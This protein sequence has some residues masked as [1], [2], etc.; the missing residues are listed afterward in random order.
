MRTIK[1]LFIFVISMFLVTSCFEETTDLDLNDD[2]FNV[3]GFSNASENFAA[4]ADGAEYP[5]QIEL[6]LIGPTSMELTEDVTVSFL[7]G[8]GS[9]AIEGTHYRIDDASVTL[10]KSNNYLG[11][12]NITMLTEGIETPLDE[13]PVL[14]LLT[15]AS[16]PA[17]VSGTGKP[18][19]VVF[20]YACF[21]D[22]AGRYDIE[23]LRDGGAIAPYNHDGAGMVDDI[24]ET[25]VGEYRTSNVGHWDW[26]T[27]LGGAGVAGFTFYDVCGVLTVP[28]QNL[29]EYYSNV[30]HGDE[31]PDGEVKPDGTLI[32]TYKI[33]SSWESEYQ[34]TYTPQK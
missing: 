21:S 30:V 26:A 28:T 32:I 12:M 25:G 3:V 18:V 23:V 16:G 17:S 19:R 10:S 14:F 15:D 33:T 34:A 9:T 29:I 20:S 1:N 24:T 7:A 6:K 4:I 5:F 13:S 2:G 8:D 31:S 11:K 27:T 22:L